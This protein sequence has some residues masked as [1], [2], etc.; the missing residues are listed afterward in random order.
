MSSVAGDGGGVRRSDLSTRARVRDAAI[1]LFATHGF[2]E[3]VRSVGAAAG[4]SAALVI[5]HFGSKA[6]LREACDERVLSII[7]SVKADVVTDTRGDTFQHLL[8]RADE[9]TVTLGYV[10]RSL[11]D[12]GPM[13]RRF[14]EHLVSD[15][16]EYVAEGVRA[17]L[18]R[19]SLDERRRVRHLTLSSLG[20]LVMAFTLDPPEDL[21]DLGTWLERYRADITLPALELYS[22]GLLTSR[23]LLDDYLQHV[24]DPPGQAG[25][26]GA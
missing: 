10:L 16:E 2:G 11:L 13:A 20:S 7:R 5:H 9:Y 21:A 12:G 15:A 19:P 3:S 22:Q 17:G 23:R 6:G 18:L 25:A 24:P 8:A 26:A 1:E 14:V 4:V